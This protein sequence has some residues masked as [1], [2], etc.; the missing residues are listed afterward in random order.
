MSEATQQEIEDALKALS[1]VK[2]P[3]GRWS[4]SGLTNRFKIDTSKGLSVGSSLYSAFSAWGR[5]DQQKEIRRAL[6]MK[7]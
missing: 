6:G 1:F 5:I 2:H 7:E 3:D 4:H